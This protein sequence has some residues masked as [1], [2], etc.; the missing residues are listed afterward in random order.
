M[1]VNTCSFERRKEALHCGV[2]VALTRPT[3]ADNDALLGSPGEG[4]GGR[5]GTAS[6]G[7][8]EHFCGRGAMD[9]CHLQSASSSLLS[10]MA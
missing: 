9:Q 6:I 1:S 10:P 2:L 5:I 8:Q 3:P 7:V 4:V